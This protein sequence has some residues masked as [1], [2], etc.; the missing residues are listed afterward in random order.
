MFYAGSKPLI[1]LKNAYYEDIDTKINEDSLLDQSEKF[2]KFF[3]SIKRLPSQYFLAKNNHV[4][5][6]VVSPHFID[7][8]GDRLRA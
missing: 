6:K 8:N 2:S 4:E 7:P 1:R 5:V 3:S